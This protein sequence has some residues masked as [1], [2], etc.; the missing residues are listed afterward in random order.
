MGNVKQQYRVC[1]PLRHPGE[2]NIT[3][4]TSCFR[5]YISGEFKSCSFMD[6]FENVDAATKIIKKI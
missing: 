3:F 6:D 2:H 1:L 4:C 5:I